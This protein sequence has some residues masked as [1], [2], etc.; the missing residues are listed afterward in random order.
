MPG[1]EEE[2]HESLFGLSRGVGAGRQCAKWGSSSTGYRQLR[3]R[4]G[5]HQVDELRETEPHPDGDGVRVVLHGADEAVVGAE[6]VVVEPLGVRV[7]VAR[8]R[9][10]A[11]HHP[12]HNPSQGWA[13]GVGTTLG[14][15]AEGTAG[16]DSVT[17]LARRRTG[18][19]QH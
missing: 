8:G 14:V 5:T 1:E 3:R 2:E 15:W 16:H 18:G 9:H 7:G 4:A 6:E 17:W 13:E 11:H 12:R 10:H 19:K